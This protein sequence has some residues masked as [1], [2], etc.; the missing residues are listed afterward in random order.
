ASTESKQDSV[1]WKRR[2]GNVL[3][4]A[5]LYRFDVVSTKITH[6]CASALV[7]KWKKIEGKNRWE[8]E[9]SLHLGMFI[10]IIA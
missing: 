1:E 9:T 8:S 3:F 2:M 10:R 6:H 4:I 7:T 5:F